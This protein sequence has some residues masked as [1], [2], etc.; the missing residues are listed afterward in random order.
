MFSEKCL[1]DIPFSCNFSRRY[2]FIKIKGCGGLESSAVDC[3]ELHS[4]LMN[5]YLLL[6]NISTRILGQRYLRGV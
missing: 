6:A 5:L 3:R 1:E 2:K 4:H